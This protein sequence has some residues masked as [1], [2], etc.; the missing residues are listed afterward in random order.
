MPAVHEIYSHFQNDYEKF[1]TGALMIVRRLAIVSNYGAAALYATHPDVT[2]IVATATP[3]ELAGI[4]RC[5]LQTHPMFGLRGA[6][7]GDAWRS[8]AQEMSQRDPKIQNVLEESRGDIGESNNL[9]LLLVRQIA[10][11]N[12]GFATVMFASDVR[13]IQ[14]LVTASV[15]DVAWMVRDIRTPMYHLRGSADLW[16]RR[17]RGSK[18]QRSIDIN[19][20]DSLLTA[21]QPAAH[22]HA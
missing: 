17:I 2:E 8:M 19:T 5:Y 1:N 7:S 9:F 21:V 16:R 22:Q 3:E 10:S 11:Y 14:N 15:S 4:P 6:I 12:L 18:D 20:D 13:V